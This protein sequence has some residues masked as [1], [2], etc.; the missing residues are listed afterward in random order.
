M[1]FLAD[2]SLEY[3]VVVHFRNLGFDITAI[4]EGSKSIADTAVLEKAYK[5]KRILLTNDTDFGELIFHQQLPHYGVVLFRL[6]HED[7][8]SKIKRFTQILER[9]SKK[10]T[11]NFIVVTMT[12]VRA[13]SSKR[14]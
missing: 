7:A 5:Q 10:L 9:F 14:K 1:K 4:A 6:P 8:I 2:E 13:R 3:A 12:K 11:N